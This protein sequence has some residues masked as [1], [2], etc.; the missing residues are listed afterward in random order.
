[1]RICIGRGGLTFHI[2]RV[3]R[4]S[5]WLVADAGNHSV[6]I[7]LRGGNGKQALADLQ[8]NLATQDALIQTQR[9]QIAAL[10]AASRKQQS[11]I[12]W[13]SE[14]VESQAARLQA[15]RKQ[16]ADHQAQLA[17]FIERA[18]TLISL[19]HNDMMA[20]LWDSLRDLP[21]QHA[22]TEPIIAVEHEQFAPPADE[23][24][25]ETDA[26]QSPAEIAALYSPLE[27]A[28]DEDEAPQA[29]PAPVPP[30]PQADEQLKTMRRF[31]D[32][33]IRFVDYIGED[34]PKSHVNRL[35]E[36]GKL[37]RHKFHPYKLRPTSTGRKWFEQATLPAELPAPQELDE[38]IDAD[39]DT[40]PTAAIDTTVDE[41]LEIAELVPTTEDFADDIPALDTVIGEPDSDSARLLMLLLG[42]A[43]SATAEAMQ[44]QFPPH[45]FVSVIVDEINEGALDL[46]D[47]NL[48]LEE[49]GK[50][51]LDE[52]YSAEVKRCL[53]NF[54]RIDRESES[55]GA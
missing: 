42:H 22:D 30:R 49:N 8:D 48:I 1:M 34:L 21:G 7:R 11:Q 36:Q 9:Q 37:E 4:Y 17:S 39:E 3:L 19:S 28:A 38:N 47:D 5:A 25:P 14:Q 6:A 23:P 33:G 26:P 53:D 46:L 35:E 15:Q 10:Q 55:G 40:Q 20:Q 41:E 45:K 2:A 52:A 12:N 27:L 43:G 44:A 16:A 29:K 13:L 31:I 50:L 24:A 32:A 54:P 51:V 18:I